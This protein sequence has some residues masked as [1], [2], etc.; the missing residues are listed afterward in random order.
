MAKISDEIIKQQDIIDDQDYGYGTETCVDC[1]AKF[2][3]FK[4]MDSA[5]KVLWSDL[6]KKCLAERSSENFRL[7]DKIVGKAN[8]Y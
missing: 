6:C 2:E 5:A 3:P 7:G 8:A 1:A 4:I